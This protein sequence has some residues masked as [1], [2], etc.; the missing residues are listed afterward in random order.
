MDK[1]VNINLDKT[2]KIKT[3]HITKIFWLILKIYLMKKFKL[4]LTKNRLKDLLVG[5]CKNPQLLHH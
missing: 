3:P 4:K 2:R 1:K 5:L